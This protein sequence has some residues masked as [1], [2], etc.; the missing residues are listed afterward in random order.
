M[1]R[2]YFCKVGCGD[3]TVIQAASQTFL[4]DCYGIEKHTH[5]LPSSKSL[6]GVF[7]THQ[8]TD[9]FAGLHYLKDKG[10]KIDF[11]I[12]SPYERRYNDGSVTYDEWQDFNELRDYFVGKG[13]ETRTPYRQTDWTKPWWGCG[14]V[15][16]RMIAPFK[17]LAKSDTREI[18]DACLVVLVNARKRKF[19][20]TG[21]ASDASL[22]KIAKNTNNYCN[23][24]LRCSHHGSDNNADLDFVKGC[25]ARFTMVSTE[26]GVY[27]NVPGSTAM[28]RYRDNTKQK[29][30]R[31]DI[32]G[33]T[34][35]EF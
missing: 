10:Y 18:H 4:I 16:F 23:D 9:H 12:Y 21:D 31:T 25:N 26:S 28:Q 2:I 22:N 34:Y 3:C 17:D 32:D 19:L 13:T 5:L 11:L 27:P 24:V 1:G 8:H 7:I 6:R 15:E 33:S 20:V 29:V 30:Y 14:D 35:W